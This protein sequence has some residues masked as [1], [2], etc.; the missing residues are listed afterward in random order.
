M[1]TESIPNIYFR[2]KVIFVGVCRLR[3]W[4]NF[5]F[6]K[7]AQEDPCLTN[8]AIVTKCKPNE[9]YISRSGVKNASK[10]CMTVF[11]Q[12]CKK[13]ISLRNTC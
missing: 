2:F 13:N 9:L 5:R 4:S 8:F 10:T 12:K 3:T 11:N 1:V 6:L 7:Y